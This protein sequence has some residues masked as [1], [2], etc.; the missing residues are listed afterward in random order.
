MVHQIR[1]DAELAAFRHPAIDVQVLTPSEPLRL[2][3]LDFD[4]A[5][6]A[7]ALERGRADAARCLER[8]RA[9]GR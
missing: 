8:W 6:M 3:P 5:G 4:P 9:G 2:R 7:G 1:R